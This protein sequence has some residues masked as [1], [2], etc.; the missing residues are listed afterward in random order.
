VE[1]ENAVIHSGPKP[2]MANFPKLERY[3]AINL[4]AKYAKQHPDA[5]YKYVE[6]GAS[7]TAKGLFESDTSLEQAGY[8]IVK[9]SVWRSPEHKATYLKSLDVFR[10]TESGRKVFYNHMD[11]LLHKVEQEVSGRLNPYMAEY[12]TRRNVENG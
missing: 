1:S 8:G 9:Y 5:P 12:L 6:L 7:L 11:G 10:R 3:L 2:H 4:I